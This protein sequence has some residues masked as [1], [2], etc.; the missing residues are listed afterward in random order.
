MADPE[1]NDATPPD[2]FRL[3][4][5][6][7]LQSVEGQVLDDVNYYLWLNQP[8]DGAPPIRFLYALECLF[9]NHTQLLVAIDEDSLS[10]RVID[11]AALVKTAEELRQLHGRISIQRMNAHAFP[12]WEE[13]VGKRLQ[14]VRLTRN[15]EG[16]Y[17]NDAF[18]LDFEDPQIIIQLGEEEG[19]KVSKY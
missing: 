15:E 8:E 5:L 9:E 2:C 10:I 12:I 1:I 18:L 13:A 14:G 17:L 7:A 16:L 4:E 3:E 11:P 19:L 6:E